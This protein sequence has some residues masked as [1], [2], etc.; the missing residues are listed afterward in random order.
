MNPEKKIELEI[1]DYLTRTGWF[2]FKINQPSAHS[3]NIKGIADL[4]AIKKSISVW[5]E[6][7]TPTGKQSMQQF[8]F[9]TNIRGKGGI[10]LIA[11]S[12]KD[13]ECLNDR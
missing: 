1:K 13:V 9:G 8:E 5:I 6:V 12:V 7:K 10:Y 2:V 11:R 3:R 4:Y